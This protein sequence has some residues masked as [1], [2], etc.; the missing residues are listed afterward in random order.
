MIS[1]TN[2]IGKPERIKACRIVRGTKIQ[3]SFVE[4]HQVRGGGCCGI[5]SLFA[6]PTATEGLKKSI[7]RPE[8]LTRPLCEPQ[9]S[10]VANIL[11]MGLMKFKLLNVSNKTLLKDICRIFE[12]YMEKSVYGFVKTRL[13]RGPVWQQN[14]NYKKKIVKIF[15]QKL[16]DFHKIL[17][18]KRI[19]FF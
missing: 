2:D 11:K 1:S 10:H 12:P 6:G 15:I 7:Y 3:S 4:T 8:S 17:C 5:W 14:E 18:Y 13:R 19:P 9:N 16:Y